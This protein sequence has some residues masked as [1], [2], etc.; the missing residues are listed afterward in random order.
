MNQRGFHPLFPR[1]AVDEAVHTLRR[2]GLNDQGGNARSAH[3]FAALKIGVNGSRDMRGKGRHGQHQYKADSQ[4]N[5]QCYHPNRLPDA[6]RAG[7]I[8][9]G[10]RSSR[11]GADKAFL[12]VDGRPLAVR[13]AETVAVVCGAV[14]LVGDPAKYGVWGFPVVAD[15]F[16]GAGPLAGIE[17]ALS[18]TTADWN[19]IVACDMPALDEVTLEAL[20]VPDCDC[21]L[22]QYPDGNVEPLCAVYHRRCHA[23][24]RAALEAGVR[25]VTDA[26]APF[27]IRYVP[28]VRARSFTN[29]NTPD[30]LEKFRHG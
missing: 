25:K 17:A 12:K 18:V 27:A 30:D 7:W 10:G 24:I 9:T 11:M 19:L 6:Q 22:P 29:L 13:A 4:G 28:V 8:L 3:Q 15:R 26:L 1:D 20:F 5:V 21:A 2:H 16:P 14:A 23:G